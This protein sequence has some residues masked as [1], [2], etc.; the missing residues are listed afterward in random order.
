MFGTAGR[1]VP[2]S[3]AFGIWRHVRKEDPYGPD[4]GGRSPPGCSAE[5]RKRGVWVFG[6]LLGWVGRCPVTKGIE[7]FRA[8][9]LRV[10]T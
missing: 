7:I 2:N 10:K 4:G 1:S 3:T 6:P 5:E 8:V 9:L